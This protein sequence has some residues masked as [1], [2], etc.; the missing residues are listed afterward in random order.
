MAADC[1]NP[2][3]LIA[4]WLRYNASTVEWVLN[5]IQWCTSVLSAVDVG[6][7]QY[8]SKDDSLY[9]ITIGNSGIKFYINIVI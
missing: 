7:F 2:C 5:E 3:V 1:I 8:T 9:V 4:K 6:G